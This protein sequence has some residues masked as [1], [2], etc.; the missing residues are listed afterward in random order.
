MISE[1]YT[2]YSVRAA[3]AERGIPA[4]GRPDS[5]RLVR[6]AEQQRL[7][8]AGTKRGQMQVQ[9][10]M[11]ETTITDERVARETASRFGLALG[12]FE[13]FVETSWD[14]LPGG[15]LLGVVSWRDTQSLE[16]FRHSELYARFRLS[17][18]SLSVFDRSF[19]LSSRRGA[20]VA[21]RAALAAIPAARTR[22]RDDRRPVEAAASP[23]SGGTSGAPVHRLVAS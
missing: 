9:V 18:T 16:R 23:A 21:V 10:L 15:V 1:G 19:P 20:R 22:R 3:M 14:V 7:L 12:E 13:G 5:D 4:P 17:P 11:N 8:K 2:D 6:K